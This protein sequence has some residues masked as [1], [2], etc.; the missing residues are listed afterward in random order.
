[1]AAAG[2][3]AMTSPVARPTPPPSTPPTRVGVSCFLTILTLPSSLALDHG[4]VVGVDQAELGVQLLDGVVVGHGVVDVG[5]DADED[6]EG[7]DGHRVTSRGPTS[8]RG[9]RAATDDPTAR[10]SPR[11]R[12][13][14]DVAARDDHAD[15][16][17]GT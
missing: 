10:C 15:P 11:Q 5:V 12:V 3:S 4:G 17:A 6:E 16:A 7:V 13:E 2:N 8:G 14:V 1:M 9:G